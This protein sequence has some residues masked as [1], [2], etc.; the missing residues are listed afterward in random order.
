M[1]EYLGQIATRQLFLGQQMGP[2]EI[3]QSYRRLCFQLCS[4]RACLQLVMMKVSPLQI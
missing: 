2:A 1:V 3:E 4:G